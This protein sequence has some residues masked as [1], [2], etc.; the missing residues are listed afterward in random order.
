[1]RM[2]FSRGAALLT[3]AVRIMCSG[4]IA[5]SWVHT[6]G[7]KPMKPNKPTPVSLRISIVGTRPVAGYACV[8]L[9][10]TVEACQQ[11]AH[12]KHS[13]QTLDILSTGL[14]TGQCSCSRWFN[15]W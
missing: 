6:S 4:I 14:A 7:N 1:M 15:V 9:L 8:Y 10:L 13:T 12:G 11:V 5:P 3:I 2:L